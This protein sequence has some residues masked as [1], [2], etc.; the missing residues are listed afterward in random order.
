M[1]G[2]AKKYK[3]MINELPRDVSMKRAK[4]T[5]QEIIDSGNPK[6]S[7]RVVRLSQLKS[8]LL[9]RRPGLATHIRFPM[10]LLDSVAKEREDRLTARNDVVIPRN[11]EEFLLPTLGDIWN[12]KDFKKKENGKPTTKSVYNLAAV[13]Q[14]ISG[15][16]IS[17][18]AKSTFTSKDG[19]AIESRNLSKKRNNLECVFQLDHGYKPSQ[20]LAMIKAIQRF[21]EENNFLVGTLTTGVN[22]FLK[23]AIGPEWHSH[24]LRGVY[25]NSLFE[26]HG[27][28][29]N[30][31]GFIK[32]ALCLDSVD[33][34]VHYST[35]RFQK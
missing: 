19:K 30:K 9:S 35:Y 12:G 29:Q 10:K 1:V 34:A 31:V 17:E 33:V 4:K 24:A 21:V 8:Y 13:A 3:A 27:T 32:E 20:W 18:I 23:K 2:L 22:R 15:R 6:D 28:S 25:A 26:K 7:T 11:F 14:L 16:R 5:I